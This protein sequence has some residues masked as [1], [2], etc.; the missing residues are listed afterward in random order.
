[1]RASLARSMPARD[2]EKERDRT[3]LPTEPVEDAEGSPQLPSASL[4]AGAAPAPQPR[5]GVALDTSYREIWRLSWPIML[6]QLLVAAVAVVDIAMVGRLG[7]GAMAAVGY[8]TQ[9][10]FMTQSALFAVG[11]ACVALMARAIGAN[12]PGG[13]RRAMAAS[14]VVAV[15]T[16][17]IVAAAVLAN[18][19]GLLGLLNAQT[20]VIE[21]SIPYLRMLLGSSILLAVSLVIE[22]G[23]RAN[24]AP[25]RAMRIAVC[26]ASVKLLLNYLLIFG[27]LGFPRLDLVG[28][29]L[30]TLVSQ[31]LGLTLFVRLVAREPRGSPIALTRQDLRGCLRLLGPV[32]RMA[33]PSVSERV[34]LNLALLSYFAILGEYGTVA[35]AAYTVGVR[36]V[37][38]AW[39]PGTGFAAAISTVVGQALGSGDEHGAER[40]SVRAV[41]LALTVAI[42][43]GLCAGLG[44]E[45]IAHAFTTDAATVAILGPFMLCLALAQPMLQVHFTLAG[46]HRGAGDTWTPLLAAAFGNWALRVPIAAACAYLLHTSLAWLW[47]ALILDHTARAAWLG[48]SFRRGRW[49]RGFASRNPCGEPRVPGKFA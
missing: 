6:S 5:P 8:A 18:P 20:E 31:V 4:A 39:I 37:S 40:A 13:A 49:R 16:A 29:G 25:L 17:M 47:V 43:L 9:F 21:L 41:G 35:V 44:R 46:V 30:A 23:L 42:M 1:M 24:R 32:A 22:N 3:A 14:I 2:Q 26:V 10:F 38:F 34:V 28:A 27:R 45:T 7:A 33:A 36:A 19:R 11:F 15:G 48:I 12:D